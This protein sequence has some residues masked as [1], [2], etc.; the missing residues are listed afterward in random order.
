MAQQVKDLVMQLQRLG[1]LLWCGFD[2]WLRCGQNEKKTVNHYL[3]IAH[4]KHI[5]LYINYTLIKKKKRKRELTP[6]SSQLKVV[7]QEENLACLCSW[8]HYS[9]WPRGGNHPTVHQRM[10][11]HTKRG[12]YMHTMEYQPTLKRN[13]VL[14]DV[15][16]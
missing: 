9:Q 13:K 5:I 2:L 14:I 10:N 4:L 7:F 12:T 8:W 1:S 6:N 16:T 3:C 15:T 11:G